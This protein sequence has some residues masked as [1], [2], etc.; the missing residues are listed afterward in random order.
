MN[1]KNVISTCLHDVLWSLHMAKNTTLYGHFL[2]HLSV[3]I[4]MV[5]HYSH[6]NIFP[7]CVLT[8]FYDF[9][10][11]F[12]LNLLTSLF[13]SNMCVNEHLPKGVILWLFTL[14]DWIVLLPFCSMI[15][16]TDT[17][18]NRFFSCQQFPTASPFAHP[19]NP[20]PPLPSKPHPLHQ[21]L[22]TLW[23]ADDSGDIK[24]GGN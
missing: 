7:C 6:N 22:S 8:M 5:L 2:K 16:T 24:E 14:E 13:T 21:T 12:G 15:T 20:F 23:C 1:L 3:L 9:S 10:I 4:F 11:Y 18:S 19:M 17:R